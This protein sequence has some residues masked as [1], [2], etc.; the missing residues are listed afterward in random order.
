MAS[1]LDFIDAKSLDDYLT[2]VARYASIDV[3]E[4]RR[5]ALTAVAYYKGND[6][7]RREMRARQELEQRWY[8]SLKTG[9]PD[10]SVYADPYF[11]SDVW[12]CWVVYSRRYLREIQKLL[13]CFSDC[14]RVGDLGCSF[15]YTTAALK[16]MFP[17]ADVYGT[18]VDGP[19]FDVAMDVGRTRGFKIVSSCQEDTDLIFASEY[20]EHF[21]RPLEHLREVLETCRPKY[22]I[23]ANAFGALSIGHFNT[24]LDAGDLLGY[25]EIS[26][27]SIGRQFN[28]E[29]RSRGYKQVETGF[30]NNRPAV[31][32]LT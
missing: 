12:A 4:A 6:D 10:Y 11:L 1:I 19:Q 8:A 17:Q 27:R 20:F 5:V 26:S 31:W 15:G 21:Q 13:H 16:E 32:G 29:L 23:V 7:L 14:T 2:L 3:I 28:K 22:L 30:W 9:T 24:Y 18:N 25:R